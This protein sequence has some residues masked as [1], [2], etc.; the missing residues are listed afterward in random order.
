MTFTNIHFAGDPHAE[1]RRELRLDRLTKQNESDDQAARPIL[2]G[3]AGRRR[4]ERRSNAIS[5]AEKGI[6]HTRLTTNDKQYSAYVQDNWDVNPQLQINLGLRWDHEEVPAFLDYVTPA[7]RSD[8]IN[9]QYP[10]IT[11]T[12]SAM[13]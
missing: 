8:R 6:F 10:G 4:F 5:D 7:E 2:R 13:C 9:S 11:M 12:P 1:G 3:N